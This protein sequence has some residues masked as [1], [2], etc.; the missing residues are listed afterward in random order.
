MKKFLKSRWFK[1]SAV[2]LTLLLLLILL[3]AAPI[4][5]KIGKQTLIDSILEQTGGDLEIEDFDI[6]LFG[7][8]HSLNNLEL[9]DGRINKL[10]L[11][12]VN[13]ESIKIKAGLWGLL[14]GS[15]KIESVVVNGLKLEISLVEKGEGKTVSEVNA[16][17]GNSSEIFLLKQFLLN[18]QLT[19]KEI[20]G[21]KNFNRSIQLNA[22]IQNLSNISGTTG[23]ATISIQDDKGG[24]LLLSGS[25]RGLINGALKGKLT[26]DLDLSPL[27]AITAN[28]WD[29]VIQ[30]G[31]LQCK[32]DFDL[33]KAIHSSGDLQLTDIEITRSDGKSPYLKMKELVAKL[34]MDIAFPNEFHRAVK[35]SKLSATG[36]ITVDSVPGLKD[37]H[38]VI[39]IEKCEMTNVSSLKTS[40]EIDIKLSDDRGGKLILFA[41]HNGFLNGQMHSGKLEADLELATYGSLIGGFLDVAVQSGHL[42]CNLKGN[43][44]NT[45]DASGFV[46]IDNLKVADSDGINPLLHISRMG[47]RVN[48]TGTKVNKGQE[49]SLLL[50]RI[51][52]VGDINL[53]FVTGLSDVNRSIKVERCSLTNAGEGTGLSG[54]LNIL[55]SD[56]EGGSFSFDASHSGLYDGKIGDYSFQADI[57]L[58]PIGALFSTFWD[59]RI[60]SGHL[61]SHISRP[62]AD[63]SGSDFARGTINVS[64]L[65]IVTADSNTVLVDMDRM[66]LRLAA[67]GLD[68]DTKSAAYLLKYLSIT[69]QADLNSVYG[70]EKFNRTVTLSQFQLMKLGNKKGIK[71]FCE[72]TLEDNV[73]NEI[74]F[75]CKHSGLLDG[76]YGTFSLAANVNLT[77][78]DTVSSNYLEGSIQSGKFNCYLVGKKTDTLE[79]K[80]TVQINELSLLEADGKSQLLKIEQSELDLEFLMDLNKEN[81]GTFI[82]H[83]KTKGSIELTGVS[84]AKNVQRKLTISKLEIFN[85]SDQAGTLGNASVILKDDS[86]GTLDFQLQHSGLINGKLES[87]TLKADF[88]LSAFG[89][90]AAPYIHGSIQSGRLLCD[91]KGS[92]AEHISLG[93]T[94]E[95]RNFTLLNSVSGEKIAGVERLFLRAPNTKYTDKTFVIESL[96]LEKPT[97]LFQVDKEGISNFHKLI[98][99][100][101]PDYSYTISSQSSDNDSTA[102][103][104]KQK[105]FQLLHLE[106]KKGSV[107]YKHP[108]LNHDFKA[109][110]LD[111]TLNNISYRNIVSTGSAGTYSLT[112]SGDCGGAFTMKA[113]GSLAPILKQESK[114]KL[115]LS[116]FPIQFANVFFKDKLNA[117]VKKGKASLTA[118]YSYTEE[119]LELAVDLDIDNV[120]ILEADEKTGFFKCPKVKL[121]TT[122]K[123]GD[124]KNV[125]LKNLEMDD[126]VFYLVRNRNGKF[127]VQNFVIPQKEESSEQNSPDNGN[128]NADPSTDSPAYF[129][130]EKILIHRGQIR[131]KDKEVQPS[132]TLYQVRDIEL[133]LNRTARPDQADLY[134]LSIDAMVPGKNENGKVD[135]KIFGTRN[136]KGEFTFEGKANFLALDLRPFSAYTEKNNGIKIRKGKLYCITQV[137]CKDD[138]LDSAAWLYVAGLKLGK[139]G[140][141][142]VGKIFAIAAEAFITFLNGSKGL[143]NTKCEITGNLY[144]PKT[145][146]NE[147][148]QSTIALGPVKL[149]KGAGA[150]L[151]NSGLSKLGDLTKGLLGDLTNILKYFDPTKIIKIPNPFK[152][153]EDD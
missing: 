25:H 23:K 123:W 38:S 117:Y 152:K 19:I 14:W 138:T 75:D 107:I 104:D 118:D 78:W 98:K 113:N 121:N 70:I 141:K 52:L 29:G 42:N 90:L 89:G 35:I 147:S 96:L 22:D 80:G 28:F 81:S 12:Q 3:I 8:E 44:N 37:F 54:E 111:L 125:F 127:S 84:G 86:G 85:I 36:H 119:N 32:L 87:A 77:S 41:K 63:E 99:N 53:D 58:A 56:S 114:G 132:G 116:E 1:Y 27:G 82:R 33:Y 91:V 68:V 97:A 72:L 112:M 131:L 71:G 88:D 62:L 51:S 67:S 143:I 65:K 47:M 134:S 108:K 60:Q 122:V 144:A 79:I 6:Q 21:V 9:R 140:Q 94:V 66:D 69:G 16:K 61:I 146:F 151:K 128:R 4:I 18:G 74:K 55:V 76:Q 130:A 95:L 124:K 92:Y 105:E 48:V 26:G 46:R 83:I 15:N 103:P 137:G 34:D 57:D 101:S 135:V 11:H 148:L 49:S 150:F 102:S 110:G 7:G 40:G 50:K 13:I 136:K 106:I 39:Q 31:H 142:T 139:T 73:G 145:N 64:A 2:I 120:E 10:L 24:S 5:E 20:P 126:P 43:Y 17:A 153:D 100:G 59:G 149:L 93:G 115:E 109:T 45:L 30:S 133:D 129:D